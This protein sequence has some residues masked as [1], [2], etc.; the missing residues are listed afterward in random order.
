MSLVPNIKYIDIFNN[1]NTRLTNYGS[2]TGLEVI[3]AR[4]TI[5]TGLETLTNKPNIRIID[6]AAS[7]NNQ[8]A[9]LTGQFPTNL[10]HLTKL[11]SLRIN[12]SSLSGTEAVNLSGCT[13]LKDIRIQNSALT[14]PHPI[15]PSYAPSLTLIN[16]QGGLTLKQRLTGN[17]PQLSSFPNLIE[18]TG[19]FNYFTGEIPTLDYNPNLQRFLVGGVNPAN[20]G[21]LTKINSLSGATSL[22]RFV[23]S[24][25]SLSGDIPSLKGLSAL[26]DFQ[27][28]TNSLSGGT[29]GPVLS[30]LG[31]FVASD[32]QLSQSTIHEIL[33]SFAAAGRN[34]GTRVLNIG[35][36]GNASPDFTTNC[37]KLT[38]ARVDITNWPAAT[39][40]RPENSFTVTARVSG[41]GLFQND[42][43]TVN[44]IGTGF[45]ATSIVL[46]SVDI[47][48][49]TYTSPTSSASILNSSASTTGRIY[50]TLT[51][52]T[53]LSSYQ[54]LTL[55]VA[56]GGLGW[57]TVT[58]NIQQ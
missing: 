52:N 39:F 46:S 40:T 21:G 3:N 41:H 5:I 26:I 28:Q 1:N 8:Y 58:I 29:I 24:V 11:E 20:K 53:P 47:N 15:L 18:Y 50:K 30:S 13:S 57:T 44:N 45:N 38:S 32:N 55:P 16:V 10:S 54:R 48:T 22:Q 33:S 27:V 19:S 12:N 36:T 7:T 17:I 4:N 25:N 2:L 35:G 42:V 9:S 34:S 14:G 6:F 43:I 23:A 31:N 37:V 49:F 56:L 51:S